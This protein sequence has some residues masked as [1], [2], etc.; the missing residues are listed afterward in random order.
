[1]ATGRL[2]ANL[3][4]FI[5]PSPLPRGAVSRLPGPLRAFETLGINSLLFRLPWASIQDT[6]FFSKSLTTPPS[7]FQ[8]TVFVGPSHLVPSPCVLCPCRL[9]GEERDACDRSL[10]VQSRVAQGLKIQTVVHD[11]LGLNHSSAPS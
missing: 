4:F 2:S 1:M 8:T 6:A 7:A 10:A 5:P 3:P 9:T 11:C